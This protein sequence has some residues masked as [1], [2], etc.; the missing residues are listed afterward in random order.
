MKYC[1]ICGCGIVKESDGILAGN[2]AVHRQTSECV[3]A[4]L[5]RAVTAEEH[6]P[7]CEHCG[8]AAV[9]FGRWEERLQVSFACSDCC[10]HGGEDGWCEPAKD[11][12]H[13][14]NELYEKCTAIGE[15][16]GEAEEKIRRLEE[17]AK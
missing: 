16:L 4:L 1:V 9:C 17:E 5:K 7:R 2:K 14:Y 10:G 15:A 12:M 3:R 6:I 11:V 8:K 13:H